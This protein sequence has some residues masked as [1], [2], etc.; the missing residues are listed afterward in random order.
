MNELAWA[1]K[2]QYLRPGGLKQ[3]FILVE[4]VHFGGNVNWYSHY[5]KQWRFL[6]KL[7]IELPWDPAIP[8]LGIYPEK[9]IIRKDISTPVFIAALLT[10]AKTWKQYK[11]PSTEKW[12][13]KMYYIYTMEY[14]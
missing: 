12:I 14:Y 11:C 1:A 9:T 8:L 2:T 13:K 10:I 3:S 6:K 4:T 7:N 5:G